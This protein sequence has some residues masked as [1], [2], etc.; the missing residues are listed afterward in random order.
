MN[1]AE[2]AWFSHTIVVTYDAA[3]G[4]VDPQA[5]SYNKHSR[6]VEYILGTG[7]A[8]CNTSN[9]A[10]GTDAYASARSSAVPVYFGGQIDTTKSTAGTKTIAIQGSGIRVTQAYLE[11]TVHL[12]TAADVTDVDSYIDVA[13]GPA[14]GSD[15]RALPTAAVTLFDNSSHNGTLKWNADVTPAF[16]RQTDAQFNSG[17]GVVAAYSVT[18]PTTILGKIKLVITYEQD[19]STVSHTETKTVRFP[20]DS[21]VSGDNG[22]KTAA[23][24]GSTTCGF[25]YTP[26]IPDAAADGNI[27]DVFFELTGEINSATASTIQP[28]I[29]GGTAA[30]TYP[31]L[32][33]ILNDISIDFAF[34][35]AVGGSD[36]S[37]SG[38]QTLNIVNGSVPIQALGGELVITYDFLTGA[39]TQ[40]ETIRQFVRQ[41]TAANQGTS[42]SANSATSVTVSNTGMSMKNVWVK[43]N[44]AVTES[45]TLT[46][47]GD[48]NGNVT[49]DGNADITNAIV[50]GGSNS[51]RAG[52]T[53]TLYLDLS[54]QASEFSSATTSIDVEKQY[55]GTSGDA[56]VGMELYFTFTWSGSSGGT[57]T[58]TLLFGNAQ[59][60][61][62]ARASAYQNMKVGINLSEDVTKT[63]RSAYMVTDVSHSDATS[64]VNASQVTMGID[65]T[66]TSSN[67]ST[68]V[69]QPD[70]G[71]TTAEEATLFTFYHDISSTLFSGG[72]NITWKDREFKMNGM[73]NQ[74]EE[75]WFSHTIV[76]TYDAALGPI[77]L[78]QNHFRWRDDSVALSTNS[79]WLASQDAVYTSMPKATVTRLRLEVAN[80][81]TASAVRYPFQL[82]YA[83]KSTTCAAATYAAVPVTATSEPFQSALSTQYADEATT[84]SSLLTA[85]GTFSNGRAVENPST[86]TNAISIKNA[87]YTELEYSIS[88][89]SN[90]NK[91]AAYCFRVTNLGSTNNFTYSI[92]PEVTISN[93]NANPDNPSSLTQGSANGLD[94]ISESSWTKYNAPY[95][96]FAVNDPDSGDTV[97][98]RVQIDGT[99]NAFS[100]IILDYTHDTL[101]TNGTV[102]AFQVGQSGG[103]YAVG[104]QGMTLSDSSTGY[105]WRVQGIDDSSAVS[106]WST[107]GTT[108]VDF[109]VDATAPT[110]LLVYDGT[111]IGSDIAYNTGSLT[112]LSANWTTVNFNISG[113]L[114]PNKY[115]YAIGTTSGGTDILTWQATNTESAV[116]NATS[117]NLHTGQMYYWTVNAYDNAGNITTVV[118]N[119][120][121]VMP[122]LSFSFS[123]NTITFDNLNNGNNWTNA[124]PITTTTST[125][126]SSGY[127]VYGYIDDYMR[128]VPFPATYI[129]DVAFSY[130][131]PQLWPLGTYGFGY[132]SN[133]AARYLGG[134]LYCAFS[135]T[136]PGDIVAEH[137]TAVNG[138]TGP[139]SL[140]QFTVTPKIAVNS[141]QKVSE[142]KTTLYLMVV[143]NF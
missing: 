20:L 10:C 53:R 90:A 46:L 104:S 112:Q 137:T 75:A 18:G 87:Y 120:Q 35:P 89:T 70:E 134:T 143:A 37:R 118:S 133:G 126:A 43:A 80:T 142:Y 41:E 115:Q 11:T 93:T 101:S 66:T 25:S 16:D 140:E 31:W 36:F 107:F 57:V 42:E 85:T 15:L 19:Y 3:L 9:N 17:L 95:L 5:N 92:Y 82:E 47:K 49:S 114:T 67:I 139:V 99:S 1:Q 21:T 30:M 27:K 71:T 76:V 117:L 60:G 132:T 78:Q 64:I 52:K 74:A 128:S 98:Y 106:G 136:I 88:A 119:G 79:G 12:V 102:F 24:A 51:I 38:A 130:S 135:H 6:T 123:P 29:S 124:K 96:G 45:N 28:Q 40:T 81:G 100:N 65:A 125:N 48:V 84:S 131:S 110:G 116:V 91:G 86:K 97:K 14:G 32:D 108:A 141:F 94:N 127:S 105:W 68:V 23:C 58:K 63:F 121:Q 13:N 34:R 50:L 54:G 56:P 122:S 44:A 7:G 111:T 77:N 83:A 55:S 4:S 59:G 129:N 22:T 8:I 69:E 73:V 103:T 72:A 61:I 113:A 33:A 109:K 2:E 138:T 39:D 62:A 26:N